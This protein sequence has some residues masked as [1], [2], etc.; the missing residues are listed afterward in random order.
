M[1]KLLIA[2][3]VLFMVTGVAY[4]AV[5]TH[6]C[7]ACHGIHFEKHAMGKS[8]IVANMS[9]QDIV[10]AL[11]GYKKGTL[12][13][14]GMGAIMHGQVAKYSVEELKEVKLGKSVESMST[15]KIKHPIK[16]IKIISHKS[17]VYI[18]KE[19]NICWSV[20]YNNKKTSLVDCSVTKKTE[21]LPFPPSP[22]SFAGVLSPPNPSQNN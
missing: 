10:K 20:D 21:A 8:K 22:P 4:A 2:F 14:Y 3:I 19:K 15:T 11:I 7:S 16:Q 18:Y 1:K 6:V 13:Q 17:N 5:N 9:N 12:N